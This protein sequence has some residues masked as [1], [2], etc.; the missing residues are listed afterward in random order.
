MPVAG[1]FLLD[2]LLQGTSPGE[3]ELRRWVAEAARAG[4]NFSL[5]MEGSR[6][7]LLADHNTYPI[8]RLHGVGLDIAMTGLLESLLALYPAKRATLS[9]TLRSQEYRTGK[10]VQCVYLIGADGA[11]QVQSRE[12]AAD[13]PAPVPP[14]GKQRMMQSLIVLVALLLLVVLAGQFLDLRHLFHRVRTATQPNQGVEL[15]AKLLSPYAETKLVKVHQLDGFVELEFSR[16]EQW[17]AAKPDD[18]DEPVVAP[19]APP[20]SWREFLAVEAVKRHAVRGLFFD[21]KGNSLGEVQV[22]L[23]ALRDSKSFVAQ[24]VI[25]KG[26]FDLKRIVVRP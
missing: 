14:T 7:S 19:G 3:D 16:G 8:S 17:D 11:V 2:G 9:S 23:D 13:V 6:F 1:T 15:D 26:Q 10:E 4:L 12:V 20:R 5:E 21:E 25:P 18:L 24:V 22:N